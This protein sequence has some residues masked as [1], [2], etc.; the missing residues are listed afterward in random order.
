MSAR[1]YLAWFSMTFLFFCVLTAGLNLVVDPYLVFGSPR[2]KGFNQVKVDINEFVRTAKAY[3]PFGAGTDV[4]IAG[5]S[6]VEMGLDPSHRCFSEIGLEAYNLG[7]PGAGVEQ[8]LNY[9]LNI[10]YAQPVSNIFLSVDFVDFIVEKGRSSPAGNDVITTNLLERRFD[11]SINPAYSWT[12]ARTRFQALLSLGALVSSA[13][14]IALQGESRP[15]R[16]ENGFNPARDFAKATAIEGPGALFAQKMDALEKRFAHDLDYRYSDGTLV[17]EFQSL[18]RFLEIAAREGIDVV[19]FTNPFHESFWRLLAKRGFRDMHSDWL[20][21]IR[22]LARSAPGS[23]AFW[24]FS[25]DSKYVHEA[26]PAPGVRAAPLQWFWEPSH[27]RKALGDKM[28]DSMLSH[29]CRSESQFGTR[30]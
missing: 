13:K 11:G 8:Q 5:N 25:A 21:E 10:I 9:V 27:Y 6:R 26:V 17:R 14:T 7:I 4:L 2:V 3:H 16:L 29:V 30:L 28:L 22:S 18:S 24:D 19:L 1:R 23:V 20:E 15:D 12:N